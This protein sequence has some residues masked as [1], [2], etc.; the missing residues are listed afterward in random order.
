VAAVKNVDPQFLSQRGGPVRAFAGNKSVHA[1]GSG[2]GQA[3]AGAAG[4]DP[5]FPADARAALDLDGWCA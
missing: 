4:D 2:L 5:N 1:L 3:T